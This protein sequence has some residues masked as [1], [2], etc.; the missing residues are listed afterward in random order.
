MNDSESNQARELREILLPLEKRVRTLTVT[1]ILL[2]LAVFLLTATVLCE[3][4]NYFG[5]D[6][7]RFDAASVGGVVLGFAVGWFARKRV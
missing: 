3:L 5:V 2:V 6:R 1:V 4:A 7:L